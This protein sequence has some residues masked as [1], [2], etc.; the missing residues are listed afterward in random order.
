MVEYRM[1]DETCLL[2]YCLHGGPIPGEETCSPEARPMTVESE[3]GLPQGTIAQ[4]LGAVC[5]AYGSCAVL[6]IDG[7]QVVGKV[8]FYPQILMD[9]LP[10]PCGQLGDCAR[11]IAAFDADTLPAKLPMI[12]ANIN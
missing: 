7:D 4:F 12:P 2:C 3:T 8:R 6:A 5:R 10:N 9:A 11:A 1:M